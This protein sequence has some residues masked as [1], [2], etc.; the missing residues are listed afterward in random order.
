MFKRLFRNVDWFLILIP[1][2]LTVIGIVFIYSTGIT[3]TGENTNKYLRQLMWV[4]ISVV[5]FLVVLWID[6]YRWVELSSYFY[7]LGIILLILTLLVGKNI[8]GSRSWFGVGGLGIQASEVMKVFYI[9]FLAK[10][11]AS[12]PVIEKRIQVFVVSSLITL[13]P[14]GLILLQPDLGTTLVYVAIFLAMGFVGLVDTRFIR[15]LVLVGMVGAIVILLIAFYKYYLEMGN[16]PLPLIDLLID[17]K[18]LFSIAVALLLYSL[19]TAVIDFFNPVGWIKKIL[20]FSIFSGMGFLMAVGAVKVLKAYQWKRILVM[21]N[22]EFD[23]AG[24]G[25]NVIQSRIAIGSGGLFGKGLFRGTQNQLGFL[26]EKDT[27]FIFSIICE[28][29]GLLGALLVLGLFFLYFS[30]MYTIIKEAKDKEGVLVT[31][32][33]FAMFATHVIINTGM[34]LGI[35]PATGLPLPFISYGGSAYLAFAMGAAFLINIHSRR[36]VH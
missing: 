22:P 9:L 29:M 10:Y 26:P 16:P 19:F 27:D 30:Y 23:K 4:G 31:V 24:A 25:Y 8:R 21:I 5:V 13:L 18:T 36:F 7:I 1:I 12:A 35:L 3:V 17:F 11:L 15:Y 28:E 6:Y 32:G 34:A 33:I 20:P 2:L 14:M